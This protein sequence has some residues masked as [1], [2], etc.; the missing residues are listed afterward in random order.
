MNQHSKIRIALFGGPGCGKTTLAAAFTAYMKDRGHQLY[1]IQEY[2]REFIDSYGKDSLKKLGPHIQRKFSEKQEKREM[3]VPPEALGFI[4]DSPIFLGW[5]YTCM[6]PDGEYLNDYIIRKDMYK[7]FLR[8]VSNY[9]HIV[10]VVREKSYVQDGTRPQTY[11][12]ALLIDHHIKE[13]LSMHQVPYT[14]AWG[15]TGNRCRILHELVKDCL[16]EDPTSWP[17]ASVV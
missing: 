16:S 9:T 7:R 2:A 17:K 14:Q 5:I 10:E 15:S 6:Y 1:C 12:E 3:D 13:A 8:S 4:T 11:D